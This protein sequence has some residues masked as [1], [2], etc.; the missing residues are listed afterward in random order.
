MKNKEQL[1]RRIRILRRKKWPIILA[2]LLVV[3][4][5]ATPIAVKIYKE[6]KRFS[7]KP[8]ISLS[9]I[10][11]VKADREK[12]EL[13]AH[14]G[15]SAVAPENTI[16]AINKAADYGF[17]TVEID[18]RQTQDGVWVLSHD[19]NVKAMT[20]KSGEISSYTYFD[21]I[22]CNIDKGANCKDYE[23]L[24]ICTLD[25]AL[26]ACLDGNIKPMIEIKDYT[27]DGLSTLL[28]I[29]NKNGFT[30]SCSIISFD[31]DVLKLVRKLNPDIKLYILTE[32]LTDSK[33]EEYLK[34]PTIGVSFKGTVKNLNEKNI[35]KLL[36]AGVSLVSWTIDDGATLKKLYKLGITSFVS[37]TIYPE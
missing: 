21:L 11:L 32:K 17:D 26:K 25:H 8:I 20:D 5:I 35:K 19:S 6:H 29:I 4:V 18:V 1:K 7:E 14:R 2:V 34:D 24:K 33:T 30:D 16:E 9:S 37:N 12:I 13:A 3:A 15:F 36:Q 28:D 10:M 22:T 23:D 27:E 31:S